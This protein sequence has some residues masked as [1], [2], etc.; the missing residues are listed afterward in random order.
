MPPVARPVTSLG[1]QGGKTFSD[2][3]SNFLSY[4]QHNFPG[5]RKIFQG[6][7]GRKP[8]RPVGTVL[9]VTKDQRISRPER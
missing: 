1:H 9:P 8:L 7:G 5:G 4:V 2:R 3:S 6:A